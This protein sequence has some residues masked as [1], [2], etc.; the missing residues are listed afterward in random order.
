MGIAA[1]S[2]VGAE[3]AYIVDCISR[4]RAVIAGTGLSS[5]PVGHV[6]T[7]TAWVNSSNSAVASASDFIGVDAYPYFQDTM[8]NAIGSGAGLF[9][10]ALSATQAAVGSKEIWITETGWPVSGKTRNLAV[11]SVANAKTY[12]DQV[13]CPRFGKANVFWYTLEDTD[14]NAALDPSFGVAPG[15]PLS[16]TPLF[17]LS[18]SNISSSVTTSGSGS[19]TRATGSSAA[20]ATVS[21]SKGA[22]ATA[23]S[24]SGAS[25][26][27]TALSTSLK[28]TSTSSS[29]KS[30]ATA[31]SGASILSGSVAGLAGA[32]VA[33]LAAL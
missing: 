12:W 28:P 6:D 11:A 30:T 13:G 24:G 27:G 19:S 5:V 17:D 3:P 31:A 29:T 14:N 32:L 7:W 21:A 2:T 18:C 1:D 33:V 15:N 20:T 4:I 16:T 26:N 25:G 22:N 10:D 9:Q 8:S 23:T